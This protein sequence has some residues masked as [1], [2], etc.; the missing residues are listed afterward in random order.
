MEHP[1]IWIHYETGLLGKWYKIHNHLPKHLIQFPKLLISFI[2]IQI[3]L[4]KHK[5]PSL[6]WHS[7]LPLLQVKFSGVIL[8]TSHWLNL[9]HW[10][11]FYIA[12][13]GNFQRLYFFFE[14]SFF[15][16]YGGEIAR[17]PRV[18]FPLP[19]LR[20]ESFLIDLIFFYFFTQGKWKSGLMMPWWN[21][22]LSVPFL[23]L[24]LLYIILSFVPF[25]YFPSNRIRQQTNCFSLLNHL[26]GIYISHLFVY[27]YVLS[28]IWVMTLISMFSCL[29]VQPIANH[30]MQGI[31]FASGGDAVSNFLRI[32][33]AHQKP[34]LH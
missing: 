14:G 28:Q 13:Y 25:L 15:L 17:S 33:Y 27:M 11:G 30:Q 9:Q 19:Y 34:F 6:T 29:S 2:I 12:V 5:T 3:L 8:F 20:N 22:D 1:L 16:H 7:H 31:S 32:T 4:L 23:A 18:I 26:I 24:L 21:Y 10:T